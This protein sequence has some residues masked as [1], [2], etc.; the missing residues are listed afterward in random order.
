MMLVD[1]FSNYKEFNSRLLLLLGE[2]TPSWG[3]NTHEWFKSSE[4]LFVIYVAERNRHLKYITYK[5]LMKHFGGNYDGR[6][7]RG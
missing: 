1:M 7:Y 6:V 5:A 3:E 4:S 2:R